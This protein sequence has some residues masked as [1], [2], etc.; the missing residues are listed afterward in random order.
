MWSHYRKTFVYLQ[1]FILLVTLLGYLH[2]HHLGDAFVQFF[3]PMQA[4]AIFGASWA[5]RIKH[6]LREHR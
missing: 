6:G 5:A 3:V 4:C 1:P 2:T